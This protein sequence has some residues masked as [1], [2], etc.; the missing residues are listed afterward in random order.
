MGSFKIEVLA[1]KHPESVARQKVAQMPKTFVGQQRAIHPEIKTRDNLYYGHPDSYPENLAGLL[2]DVEDARFWGIFKYLDENSFL[3]SYQISNPEA[4]TLLTIAVNQ[5]LLRPKESS[6][7]GQKRGHSILHKDLVQ[8]PLPFFRE[9]A[10][11]EFKKKL[12]NGRFWEELPNTYQHVDAGYGSELV[13]D[14]LENHSGDLDTAF[15]PE[16]FDILHANGGSADTITFQ[17]ISN[18]AI[19]NFAKFFSELVQQQKG[20]GIKDSDLEL[21]AGAYAEAITESRRYFKHQSGSAKSPAERFSY[22]A[23]APYFAHSELVRRKVADQVYAQL[24]LREESNYKFVMRALSL[25]PNPQDIFEKV[26]LMAAKNTHNISEAVGAAQEQGVALPIYFP[27][28]VV[29]GTQKT[30]L[31]YA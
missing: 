29:P 19:D 18:E 20:L 10:T 15:A 31:S 14:V 22:P 13:E 5:A 24:F 17:D 1:D 2:V 9:V 4:Q 30:I 25:M 16:G 28:T 6:W 12:N 8:K 21:L 26:S 23:F 7:P 3:I 27:S 11:P